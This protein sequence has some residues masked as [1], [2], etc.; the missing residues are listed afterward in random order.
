MAVVIQLRHD[1][2]A[3]WTA[4]N[5]ILAIGEFGYETDTNRNKMGDGTSH[6]NTLPYYG[7]GIQGATGPAGPHGEATVNFGA[8]PGKNEAFV[9]V[10]DTNILGTS[11][12]MAMFEADVTSDHTISDHNYASLISS[13][14]CSEPTA[15]VGF[16]IYVTCLEQL[17][18]TFNLV[19]FWS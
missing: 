10:S 8:L 13:V 14:T 19:Y 12:V 4:A 2:A 6:W 5:P 15:G 9:F 7:A 11:N 17:S 1:T 16:T 3:N 18:G